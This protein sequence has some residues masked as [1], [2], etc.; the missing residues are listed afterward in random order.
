MRATPPPPPRTSNSGAHTSRT[1][2]YRLPCWLRPPW[3]C[4]AG[5]WHPPVVRRLRLPT[6][7]LSGCTSCECNLRAGR[8]A[9]HVA[10]TARAHDAHA[11]MTDMH[12]WRQVWGGRCCVDWIA[13]HGTG[14]DACPRRCMAAVCQGGRRLAGSLGLEAAI[15]APALLALRR[16]AAVCLLLLLLGPA[17]SLRRLLA[18]CR[19]GCGRLIVHAARHSRQSVSRARACQATVL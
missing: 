4:R 18:R 5:A 17:A 15:Y 16:H 19:L 2:L 6:D 11:R 3:P 12:G 7:C 10:C 13:A 8:A 1:R 14:A 9:R